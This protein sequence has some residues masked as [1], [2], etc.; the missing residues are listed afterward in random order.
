MPTPVIDLGDPYINLLNSFW[1]NVREDLRGEGP[2]FGHVPS[3]YRRLPAAERATIEKE[4]A[5]G[6]AES[7]MES[8]H[9]D[10]WVRITAGLTDTEIT[11]EEMREA[12]YASH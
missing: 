5:R 2:V 7:F 6:L 3:K 11:P 10:G 12:I 1:Q 4:T 8:P 9:F